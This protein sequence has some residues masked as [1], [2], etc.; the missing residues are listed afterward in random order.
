MAEPWCSCQSLT[1][2]ISSSKKGFE[3]VSLRFDGNDDTIE[4]LLEPPGDV[5]AVAAAIA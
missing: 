1:A 5:T 4:L 3:S 2:P